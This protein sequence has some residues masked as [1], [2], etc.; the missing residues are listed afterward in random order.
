MADVLDVSRPSAHVARVWLNRPDVRNAFND[1]VIAALT[2][3]F[4]AL[5]KDEDLRVVM[6]ASGALSH[7][8]NRID[9]TPHHPRIFHETNVSSP[10]NVASDKRAIELMQQGRHDQVLD[11]W[12]SDFRKRPWE[13]FGGHYL[14]MLGAIGGKSCTAKGIPLSAYENAR[15]TGN[16][17]IWFDL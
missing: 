16:I 6:L 10:E 13:A 11:N 9:W 14:Q 1:D 2:T 4:E 17:H 15:G 8:F 12:D 5:S 7:R 3:T